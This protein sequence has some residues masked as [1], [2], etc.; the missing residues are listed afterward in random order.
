[1]LRG[2]SLRYWIGTGGRLVDPVRM[3]PVECREIAEVI[4]RLAERIDG[5]ET[6]LEA[7]AARDG[8]PSAETRDYGDRAEK[9]SPGHLGSHVGQR[10]C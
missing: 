10:A 6:R 5:L 9:S 4:N 8:R 3:S 1:M 7:V 2:T